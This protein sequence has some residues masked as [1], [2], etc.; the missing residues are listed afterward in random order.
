MQT[1]VVPGVLMWSV[2]QPDR[3]FFFNSFFVKT[4]EGNLVVDPLPGD[5]ALFAE[6]AS[7]GGI[8][9]IV[10]TNRDHQR[11]AGAFAQRFGAKIAASEADTPLLDVAVD[12]R[13]RDDDLILGARVLA[14]DGLKTPGEIALWLREG[15]ALIV[16]DALWG[17]PAGSLRLMPAE[18]LAD[19]AAAILS[20]RKLHAVF[21][22]H[23]LVGDGACI[24][25]DARGVLQRAYEAQAG[26]FVHRV[27]LDEL[28]LLR[29]GEGK[30]EAEHAEIGFLIGGERLGYRVARL[31]PGKVFSPMHWHSLEEE[32]FI[33][34]E[35]EPS[36]RNE[37]GTWRLRRGDLIA[38]PTR[39]AGAHQLLN[40][41]DAPAVIILIG[42]ND[43][44][45]DCFYP[46][47]HKVLV[48]KT[49]LIVRDHPALDYYDGE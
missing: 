7:L 4:G 42:I 41:S 17:D 1:T 30:F 35:G 47:S 16:G 12:R 23:V 5:D 14:F 11:A 28:A 32:L 20:L 33:V 46:D 2:W 18:K 24:F 37:R 38:F 34:W 27:N 40:E 25:G 8:H 45:D 36:I 15:R 3:N 26:V 49:D 48:G 19:P 21:P 31:A 43:A 22:E 13:L 10:V 44:D 9:W 29:R 6:I 39:R